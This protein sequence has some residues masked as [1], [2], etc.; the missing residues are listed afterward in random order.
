MTKAIYFLESGGR[1]GGGSFGG[2][3]SPSSG[4]SSGSYS[5]NSSPYSSGDG[6]GVVVLLLL[7][8]IPLCMILDAAGHSNAS[9]DVSESA[10]TVTQLQVA[11]KVTDG[12]V[13][14][15]LNRT[16]TGVLLRACLKL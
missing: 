6:G 8:L 9:A 10:A 4:G 15:S 2:S 16:W 1:A 7:V 12:T 3:S 13:Q 5:Y 14:Q 11:L